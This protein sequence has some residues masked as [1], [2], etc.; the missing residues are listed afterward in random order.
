MYGFTY[1]ILQFKQQTE[2]AQFKFVKEVKRSF[3]ENHLT[4][5]MKNAKINLLHN[6]R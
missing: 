6:F 3:A 2:K 1:F 5:L 4:M